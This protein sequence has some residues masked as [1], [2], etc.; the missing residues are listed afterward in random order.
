MDKR[1]SVLNVSVS[2]LSR[3]LLLAAAL[4]V[5]RLLIRYIGN[6]VNGLDS[7]YTHLVGML[8]VAELGVGSAVVFSMYRPI[9]SGDKRQVA[10]LYRLYRK[11][12]RIVSLV[13]LLAGL[14]VMPFLSRPV[15]FI[16]T[17]NTFTQYMRRTLLLFRD[18]SGTFYYDRWKAV[19]EGLVN[20]C[21]SLLFVC[22]FPEDTRVVGVIVA[23]ILTTL[24]IC[25]TVEP[26]VVFRH[27]FG[28]S[29]R[30]FCLRNYSYIALFTACLALLSRIT[31]PSADVVSGFLVNGLISVGV[32]AAALGLLMLFDRRFRAELRTLVLALRPPLRFR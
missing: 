15:A 1:R 8:S 4:C 17:L 20:L 10:A 13:I 18:A 16:I 19:A 28:E 21:L 27:V 5:K 11:C 29:P 3:L 32:S 12:Y 22:V 7:F 31:Q 9:V 24:L 14:A 2:V 23:T 30:K 25:D 6:D 26:Y